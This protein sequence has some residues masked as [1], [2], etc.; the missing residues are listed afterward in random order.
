MVKA[1]IGL[2][3]VAAAI[4]FG[5]KWATEQGASKGPTTIQVDVPNPMGGGGGDGDVIYV[6]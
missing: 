5:V 6:P 4:A 3:L 1:I 2:A